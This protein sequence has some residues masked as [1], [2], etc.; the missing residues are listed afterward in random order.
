MCVCV[1]TCVC[2][3]ACVCVCVCMYVCVCVCVY[4]TCVRAR[5]RAR[6]CVC[7]RAHARV[8]RS[9]YFVVFL[10]CVNQIISILQCA[11]ALSAYRT[12]LPALSRRLIKNNCILLL[13][14][15]DI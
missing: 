1:C 3:R 5:A 11:H 10:S 12:A 14:I 8:V 9:H 7:V 6:V 15:I 2:V 4:V 13:I